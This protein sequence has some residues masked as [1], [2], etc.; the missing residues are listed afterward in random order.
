MYH[1]INRNGAKCNRKLD[2]NL[3]EY[4]F[5]WYRVHVLSTLNECL[6]FLESF[7]CYNVKE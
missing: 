7:V 6:V 3:F 5:A 1:C 2:V 4:L